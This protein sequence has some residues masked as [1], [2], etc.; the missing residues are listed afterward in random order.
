M[1]LDVII[2]NYKSTDYLINCIQSIYEAMGR[3]SVNILV[4]DNERD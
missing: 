2:V 4:Q 1:Q 3:V